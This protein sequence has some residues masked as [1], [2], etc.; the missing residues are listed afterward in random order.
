MRPDVPAI[1]GNRMQ[2]GLGVYPSANQHASPE[3]SLSSE[4]RPFGL[5]V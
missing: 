5:T 2:K 4:K 3:G 1:V